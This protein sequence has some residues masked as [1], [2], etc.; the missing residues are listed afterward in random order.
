MSE[1]EKQKQIE[2]MAKDIC[3]VKQNCND[4][5]HPTNSCRALKYAVRL[6][7]AGYRK[8][9]WISVE[10]RLPKKHETVLVFINVGKYRF[11]ST[12]FLCS[13]GKWYDQ[14]TDVT[15]WIPLPKPPN[16]KGE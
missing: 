12:D 1:Q 6:Y 13:S 3:C 2:E 8:Q 7:E 9:E 5:C 16:T 15:H 10:D 11:I 14:G 4:I